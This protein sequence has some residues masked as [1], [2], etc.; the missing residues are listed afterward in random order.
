VLVHP[1][2]F[3]NF[4]QDGFLVLSLISLEKDFQEGCRRIRSFIAERG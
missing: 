3:F 2:K 1:G 4:A